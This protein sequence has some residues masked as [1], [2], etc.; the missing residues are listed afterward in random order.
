MILCIINFLKSVVLHVKKNCNTPSQCDAH[1][2]IYQV[3]YMQIMGPLIGLCM[4]PQRH[5]GHQKDGPAVV[6]I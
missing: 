2:N 3:N 4:L 5:G 6:M 1:N